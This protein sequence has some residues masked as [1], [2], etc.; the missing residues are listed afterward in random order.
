MKKILIIFSILFCFIYVS[1]S[2]IFARETILDFSSNITISKDAQVNI[3]ETIVYDFGE[4]QRRGIIREIP[5]TKKTEEGKTFKIN[6]NVNSVTDEYGEAYNYYLSESNNNQ[7]IKIGEENK[8]ITGKHTYIIDYAV[9]G[10]ITY[11]S[12]HDELYWNVTGDH[13]TVP[14]EIASSNIK[15]NFPNTSDLKVVCYTG[16]AGN[17]TA[18][19]EGKALDQSEV[20][21]LTTKPL[22]EKEGLTLAISFPKNLV[23]QVEPKEV[24]SFWSTTLGVLMIFFFIMVGFIYYFI[25]PL[26]VAFLWFKYGRDPKVAVPLRAWYDPP[27]DKTGK[28]MLPAEVGTLIDERADNK[29]ISATIVDLAIRGF[30]KIKEI[31][32]GKDYSLEKVKDYT[33]EAVLQDYEKKI[34]EKFFEEK[35]TIKTSE[36]KKN[37]Y[38]TANQIKNNLY[39]LLVSKECFPKNPQKVRQKYYILAILAL[40][41]GNILLFIILLVVGQVM[42]RKTIFGAVSQKIAMGMKN[43]LTSQERQLKFQ[44]DKLFLFEKLLPYA[45]VFGVEKIWAERFKDLIKT[46]PSWYEGSYGGGFNS[47]IFISNLSLAT[48]YFSS[49]S[50]LS[51]ST[52]STSGFSSGFSGG[53]SGGGFGGGGGSSW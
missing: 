22:E 33:K 20:L 36:L 52:T 14:I 3:K 37:F 13:W 43:F 10:V 4:T 12:D 26:I 16:Q 49:M 39:E 28:E 30:I 50:S 38:E 25:S 41:T 1:P 47:V 24:T 8:F 34:L 31:K 51:T 23:V 7:T 9:S 35:N 40:F 44:A 18:F 45:I 29:D 5:L 2:L 15:L 27:K 17:K 11:F 21:V 42:P 6:L 46:P 19:C 48:S 53:S 32:K